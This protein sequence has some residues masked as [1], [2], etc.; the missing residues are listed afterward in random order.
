MTKTTT[1]ALIFLLVSCNC[2][3]KI[4]ENPGK[5][6]VSNTLS[7]C[8]EDGK[9]E[10]EY[11]KNKKIDFKEDTIGKLFYGMSESTSTAVIKFQYTR[12]PLDGIQDSEYREEI[13][14]EI[15]SNS[16]EINL[17]DFTIQSSKMLFGRFCF[18]RGQTGFYKV[19]SGN[20]KLNQNDKE[21]TFDL[22][23]K[24][25]ELPQII[26]NVKATIKK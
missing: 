25:I 11:F 22:D 17:S 19:S 3:K 7:T 13:I 8:P 4:V 20:L 14:F 6:A 12:N 10:I 9:C 24:I 5:V 1:L 2:K 18:C 21:I 23:L 26:K 15:D 16:N